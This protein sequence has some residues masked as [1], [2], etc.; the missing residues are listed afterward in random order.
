MDLEESDFNLIQE[1]NTISLGFL[2]ITGE[3]I[4]SNKYPV[5]KFLK[6][7][8]SDF[9]SNVDEKK[10]SKYLATIKQEINS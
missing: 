1:K 2:T 7:V 5:N 9:T 6:D 3:L 8:V 4:W 10:L